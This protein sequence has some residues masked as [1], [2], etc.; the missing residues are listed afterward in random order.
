MI[1]PSPF[2][3]AW[4]NFLCYGYIVLTLSYM[5]YRWRAAEKKKPPLPKSGIIYQEW[6]A[7]GFSEAT[8]LTRL[9]SAKNCLRL[10]VTAEHLVI[11]A[12]FPFVLFSAF[13]DLEHVIPLGSLRPVERKRVFGH[14]YLRLTYTDAPGRTHT[15]ALES[16]HP[17]AF[18]AALGQ[19]D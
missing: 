6:F 14:K 4:I 7:S 10:I 9:G 3:P 8:L 5:I 18:L 13:Y 15:I 2:H 11:T 19:A 17:E 12:W 16:K 1:F